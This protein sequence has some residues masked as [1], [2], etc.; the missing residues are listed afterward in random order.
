MSAILRHV[1]IN[2]DDVPRARAFYEKVFGWTFTPWGPPGFY[3]TRDA[4]DFCALQARRTIAGQPMPGLESTFGVE[5]IQATITAIEANGGRILMQPFHIETVG[6]LIWFQ[7]SE[8]NIA[9][10]MQY[11]NPP[12]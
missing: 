3:Q 7:D 6:T 5:D 10:A 12:S 11:D 8:G 4:G 1:A 9:G 2:A